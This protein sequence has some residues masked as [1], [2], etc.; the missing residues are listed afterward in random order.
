MSKIKITK[1]GIIRSRPDYS[2]LV[3]FFLLAIYSLDYLVQ[4]F[5]YYTPAII[6]ILMALQERNTMHVNALINL[7]HREV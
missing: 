6:G 1:D 3:F 5:A 2:G 4:Q 7:G